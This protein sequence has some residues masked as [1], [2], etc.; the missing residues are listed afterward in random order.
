MFLGNFLLLVLNYLAEHYVE[1]IA[2]L[3]GLA[4]LFYSI[5]GDKL[6]WIFGLVSSLLYVYICYQSG[7]YADMGI[8]IYY[9]LVSIYGWIHW[10][11]FKKHQHKELPICKTRLWQWAV[12]IGITALLFGGI[13]FILVNFT[14]SNIPYLDAFTTAASITATWM[15]ARKMMEHWLIWIVVDG[16]SVGLYYYK[17][18]YP[19]VI[20]F[21]VYT[22]MAL[23]GW[24]EWKKQWKNQIAEL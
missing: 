2:T 13:A 1:I 17:N 18:L 3:A 21:L 8:N 19:T 11:W 24:Y 9:V 15:L 6:L 16:M 12:I 23:V 5:K 7:I 14:N 22:T 4:Y 20:L 10:T